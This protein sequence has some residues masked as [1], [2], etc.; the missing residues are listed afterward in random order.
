MNTFRVHFTDHKY[1]DVTTDKP[2]DARTAKQVLAYCKRARVG[3]AKVKL[4][5][6]KV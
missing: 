4:L 1:V 2:D 3:I 6:Q 5:K